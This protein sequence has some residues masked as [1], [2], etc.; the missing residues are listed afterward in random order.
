MLVKEIHHA[1]RM[2]EKNPDLR[3]ESLIVSS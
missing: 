1:V 2:L 3:F